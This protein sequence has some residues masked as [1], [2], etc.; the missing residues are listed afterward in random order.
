MENNHATGNYVIT[1]HDSKYMT[2]S[3][4][5]VNF[6]FYLEFIT[7]DEYIVN[8]IIQDNKYDAK[9]ELARFVGDG[10]TD[11]YIILSS[12]NGINN[13]LCEKEK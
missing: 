10:Y 4:D 13:Y 1:L 9:F 11:K 12:T 2:T 3:S 5:Y 6:W 7:T 8:G